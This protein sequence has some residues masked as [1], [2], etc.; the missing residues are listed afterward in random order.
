[1]ASSSS[2]SVRGGWAEASSVPAAAPSNVNLSKMIRLDE[3]EELLN[4]M[5]ARLDA[6]EQTIT[7][8]Q[9]LC[10]S[11]LSKNSANEVFDNIQQSLESLSSRLDRVQQAATSDLG[12]SQT[13]PAG[14][15]AYLNSVDIQKLKAAVQEC[16]RRADVSQD[17]A[18]LKSELTTEVEAARAG[19][20]PLDVGRAL[21]EAQS[22]A[23]QRM[24]SV[25]TMLACKVDRSDVA[26]LSTLATRLDTYSSFLDRTQATFAE[27]ARDHAA[28]VG[29]V[30]NHTARLDVVDS[31]L[32]Q[33][34]AVLQT[35]ASTTS[36]V[37]LQQEAE[38][39][40]AQIRLCATNKALGATDDRVASVLQRLAAKDIFDA[41]MD[42]RVRAADREIAN[43]ATLEQNRACVLRSHYDQAV[44]ALGND[45]DTKADSTAL[46]KLAARV[47]E[48]GAMQDS[49]AHK[50]G[51]AMRFVDWFTSRGENYE[52]NLKLVDKHLRNL[53]VA[54]NPADRV[55]FSGQV[56]FAPFMDG[57]SAEPA[58]L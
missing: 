15:L 52:H 35:R 16:S 21:Q 58:E 43:R 12:G 46:A 39:L 22:N 45:L 50:L 13:L 55:P 14:E 49:E 47:G 36:V 9:R 1:M 17:L 27:H 7:T 31:T 24:T 48:M 51:V 18:S 30:A 5:M 26:T 33:L 8:L 6:Q 54:A 19:A 37:E 32:Q 10:A 2:S 44:L 23:A 25:E 38:A 34:D 41:D 3:V 56:R 29:Q 57:G 28:L 11:L 40:A 20:T 4:S 53:A 42:E